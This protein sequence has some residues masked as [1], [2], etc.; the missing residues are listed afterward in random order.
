MDLKDQLKALFPDHQPSEEEEQESEDG[1]WIQYEPLICKHEKRRGKSIT[2][3]ENYTGNKEDFEELAR[4][5]KTALGVG[6][7]V[8]D[9]QIII[10]GD[11]RPRIMKILKELGFKVKRVGG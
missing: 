2:I 5:L 11:Y 9:E 1:L 7:T 8:K 10:Q 3:I 6:G 4:E